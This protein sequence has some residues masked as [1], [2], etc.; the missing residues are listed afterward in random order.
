MDIPY[1]CQPVQL[2]LVTTQN[3]PLILSSNVP[4]LLFTRKRHVIDVITW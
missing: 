1:F 3:R 2:K 4:G